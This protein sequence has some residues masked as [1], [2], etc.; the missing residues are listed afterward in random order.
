MNRTVAD[1]GDQKLTLEQFLA[2]Y[3]D[4]DNIYNKAYQ[5]GLITKEQSY[6]Y[7]LEQLANFGVQLDQVEKQKITLSYEEEAKLEQDVEETIDQYLI[8]N[9]YSKLGYQI[10]GENEK[11]EAALKLL[12]E[13][14][15][16]NGNSYDGYRAMTKDNLRKNALI[17]KL[18][19][20]TVSDVS[21]TDNDLKAYL[22]EKVSASVSESDF[23]RGYNSFINGEAA[24]PPLRIPLSESGDPFADWFS[25]DHLLIKFTNGAAS[26]ETD[27]EEYASGDTEVQIRIGELESMLSSLTTERFLSMCADEAFCDDPGMTS[28]VSNFFSSG[29]LMQKSL[30]SNFFEGFGYA[31]M[32]LYYGSDWEDEQSWYNVVFFT[33]ADGNKVARVFTQA[34][35]HYIIL[36]PNNAPLSMYDSEGRLIIPLFENGE[37]VT[38]GAG[39]VTFAGHITRE[40]YNA[41]DALYSN[42][43]TDNEGIRKSLSIKAVYDS[44]YDTV[45]SEKQSEK[46]NECIKEWKENTAITLHKAVIEDY[47]N[48]VNRNICH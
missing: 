31:C 11:H 9:Y 16:K 30:I 34:G 23:S 6:E 12:K 37:P 45:L 32:K 28:S 24:T 4:T 41:L 25:V 2:L 7:T 38:D 17:E 44:F 14:L 40:Q 5:F 1:V 46:Y 19:A 21:I 47:F 42:V 8:S 20:L 13:D 36:N 10:T 26:D 33:L 18:R 39:V 43:R 27:F 22:D 35:A 3:N 15:K 29:Y 48:G